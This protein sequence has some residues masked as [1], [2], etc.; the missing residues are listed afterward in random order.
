MPFQNMTND[1]KWNVWQDGIQNDLINNLNN[2]KE[3][4]VRETESISGLL[5]SQGLT[6]YAS[7]TTSIARTISQKMDADVCIYGSIKQADTTIRVNAELIDSKT[8]DTFKSFQIDGPAKDILNMT[9]S[10]SKM[11]KDFLIVSKL[12]KEVSPDL[13]PYEYTNSPEAYENFIIAN[14][15]VNKMDSPTAIKYLKEAVRIDTNFFVSYLFISIQYGQMMGMYE[16]AKEWCLKAY[17]KRDLMPIKEKIMT[18]WVHAILFETPHEEIKNLKYYDDPD[19]QVPVCYW[20]IGNAYNK[21]FQYDKAIPEFEKTLKIYEKWEIKPMFVLNYTTLGLAYHKTKQYNKEKILYKKAEQDFPDDPELIYRQAILLLS[22]KDTVSGNRYI[23]KYIFIRKENSASE[24]AISTSIAE[25]FS[26]GGLFD[27][28]EK[29]YQQALSLEPENP[30]RMNNLAYF[31]I[32]KERNIN[33]G[34]ELVNKALAISPENYNYLH[35]KGLGLYMQSKYQDALKLIQKS[36]S[37][38][39]IYNH[40]IFLHL[41]AAKKAVASQKNN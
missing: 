20:Q 36:D 30:V 28:A 9:Y 6:N 10:L 1:T 29:Y 32:D 7:I 12:G 35:T 3:L 37:L 34:L 41:E 33:K 27:K 23:D 4:K 5:Q 26:E 14:N 22:E 21:L 31:L 38:K 15:A 16:D 11:V 24:A 13:K 18:D 25:I 19:E 39:P 17:K 8:G 40:E 2:S